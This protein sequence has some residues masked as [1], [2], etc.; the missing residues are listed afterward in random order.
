MGATMVAW[1]GRGSCQVS[2]TAMV[3]QPAPGGKWIDP[4]HKHM[5]SL[6]IFVYNAEQLST[7]GNQLTL[8]AQGG[9]ESKRVKDLAG[10]L[11]NDFK[12]CDEG[13]GIAVIE[14]DVVARTGAAIESQARAN[15]EGNGLGCGLANGLRRLGSAVGLVHGLPRLGNHPVRLVAVLR[16]QL[17]MLPQHFFRR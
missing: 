5:G 9:R 12:R 10:G 4:R 7:T 11:L 8:T 2:V 17:P 13:V 3:C 1:C 16:G 14:A 6:L 15:G